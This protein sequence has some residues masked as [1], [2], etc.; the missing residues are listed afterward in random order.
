MELRLSGFL[1]YTRAKAISSLNLAAAAASPTPTRPSSES[2]NSYR[3]KESFN[4]HC[5]LQKIYGFCDTTLE[6]LPLPTY[7]RNEAKS[8]STDK[9]SWQNAGLLF[10]SSSRAQHFQLLYLVGARAAKCSIVGA[11]E[12]MFD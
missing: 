2:P 3:S 8:C 1:F 4:F 9:E 12:I 11:A 10:Y 7:N 5:S 6:S